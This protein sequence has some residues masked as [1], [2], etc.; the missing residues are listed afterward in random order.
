MKALGDFG[1]SIKGATET[2]ETEVKSIKV[3]F[4]L[5]YQLFQ[6]LVN[7]KLSYQAKQQ[8]K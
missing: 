5:F 1:L 2:M 3:D 6:A 4:L 8:Q 7:K